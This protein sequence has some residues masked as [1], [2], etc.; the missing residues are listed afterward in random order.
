MEARDF[1]PPHHHNHHSAAAASP[2][3]S[4]GS[5]ALT[6]RARRK[7]S[8]RTSQ[9][10]N[11]APPA[12]EGS[13]FFLIFP[14]G[15]KQRLEEIPFERKAILGSPKC[16]GDKWH[17]DVPP[18]ALPHGGDQGFVQVGVAKAIAWNPGSIDRD[19]RRAAAMLFGVSTLIPLTGPMGMLRRERDRGTVPPSSP[20]AKGRGKEPPALLRFFSMISRSCLPPP[21]NYRGFG[22]CDSIFMHLCQQTCQPHHS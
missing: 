20:I 21:V 22:G 16:R 6:F 7:P 17:R 12:G 19:P 14:R 11:K 8:C 2:G 15:L 18:P 1:P 4:P 3:K 9:G 5:A 13:I 10:F